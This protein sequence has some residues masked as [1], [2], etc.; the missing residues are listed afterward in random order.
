MGRRSCDMDCN[1]YCG[2]CPLS[3]QNN[4]KRVAMQDFYSGDEF[5]VLE[6]PQRREGELPM[7]FL[8]RSLAEMARA[9]CVAYREGCEGDVICLCMNFCGAMLG[10]ESRFI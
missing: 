10:K 6:I 7:E 9:D 8:G 5:D 3:I 1:I 2:D 4:N